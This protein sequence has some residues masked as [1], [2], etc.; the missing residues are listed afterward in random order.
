MIIEDRIVDTKRF[1]LLNIHH[2]VRY[3][4][5][6]QILPMLATFS[7]SFIFLPFSTLMYVFL[8]LFIMMMVYKL[9]FDV[10][11][12]TARGNM[13]STL[14]QNYLVTNGVAIKVLVVALLIELALRWIEY[15]AYGDDYKLY[16]TVF[17]T[18]ITPAIYMSLALT[19]SLVVA[20]NP[21]NIFK[22]IKT[23]SVSYVSF[24]VFWFLTI[25]LHEVVLNPLLFE[26]FP[27]FLN[28]IV[29]LFIELALLIL[30]FQIMGYI[31]F[32]NRNT[33]NLESLG[34]DRVEDDEIVIHKAVVNPIYE[35]IKN[36]LADDEHHEALA[37]I[38][39]LQSNGDTSSQVQDLYKKAMQM[40]LY[41]PSNIDIAQKI[42]KRLKNSEFKRAF[43]LLADHIESG[44]EYVETTPE[45]IKQLIQYSVQINNTKYIE[46]LVK[47]FDG[48]Y[49]YHQDIVANYFLFAK[50]LYNDRKTR[51]QSRTILQNLIQKYPHDKNMPEIKSWFKGIKLISRSNDQ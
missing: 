47:D 46:I 32:Q 48:K 5:G 3:L 16:F 42:N 9:A 29:S 19:N 8:N 26:E 25:Q 45:N 31:I 33:F 50:V 27:M 35:R 40:K 30:N 13:S 18:F 7:L 51:D 10:L 22:V 44:K 23:T 37:M 28:G 6:W 1:F 20:L 41:S 36:L 24:V 2:F 49:P 21:L 12:D 34:F 14:K 43:D 11:V 39:E 4:F 17:A 15:K 38:V